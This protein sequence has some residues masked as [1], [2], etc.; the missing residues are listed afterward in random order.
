[1]TDIAV[2]FVASEKPVEKSVGMLRKNIL[3][4]ERSETVPR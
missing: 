4:Q 2:T 1:M 3:K